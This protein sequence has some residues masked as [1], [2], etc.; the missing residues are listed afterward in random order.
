[1]QCYRSN[2]IEYIDRIKHSF[3]ICKP[4]VIFH[5]HPKMVSQVVAKRFK[6][7]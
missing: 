6:K 7:L 2:I 5:R 3:A 4:K 1:M